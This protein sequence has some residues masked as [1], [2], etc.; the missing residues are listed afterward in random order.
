M[1][2]SFLKFLGLND[3]KKA[4]S[5]ANEKNED[6]EILDEDNEQSEIVRMENPVFKETRSIE[7]VDGKEVLITK[8]LSPISNRHAVLTTRKETLKGLK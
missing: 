4:I 3:E 8:T 2:E 6:N 1:I 5:R 7:V